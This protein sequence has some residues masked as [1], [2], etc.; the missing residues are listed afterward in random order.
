MLKALETGALESS[1]LDSNALLERAVSSGNEANVQLLLS[2]GSNPDAVLEGSCSPLTRAIEQGNPEILLLLL[3]SG[4]D[5]DAVDGRGL[6]PVEVAQQHDNAFA[7][8]VLRR[9]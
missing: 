3:S 5:A 9:Q 1:F 8:S 2:Y 6:S 4:A 7:L